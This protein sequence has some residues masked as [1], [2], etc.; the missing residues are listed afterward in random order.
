LARLPPGHGDG[1]SR[2]GQGDVLSVPSMRK[3]GQRISV[4]FTIVAL[5]DEAGQMTGMAAL[6]RDVTA[7]FDEMK[8][9]KQRLAEA[10]KPPTAITSAEKAD[11]RT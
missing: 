2:Y 11:S 1:E 7:R 3:G 8:A 6:M 4:E 9:L 5:K 10:A